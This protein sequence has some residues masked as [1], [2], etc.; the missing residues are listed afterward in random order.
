MTKKIVLVALGLLAVVFLLWLIM[1]DYRRAQLIL[2]S[3]DWNYRLRGWLAAPAKT[4]EEAYEK[5]RQAL[6]AG[7]SEYN[8]YLSPKAQ[9]FYRFILTKEEKR[10]MVLSWTGPLV[11]Q[12]QTE[13][14]PFE[15]CVEMAVYDLTYYR[16]EFELMG[17]KV[18]AGYNTREIVFIKRWDGGWWIKKL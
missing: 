6:A 3:R 8:R 12:Y 9:E 7:G 15:G 11:K 1:P 5:F 13:C 10:Q 16:Q 14:E 17:Q 4:P 18:E 2:A